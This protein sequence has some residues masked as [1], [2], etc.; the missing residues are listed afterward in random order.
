[1]KKH[2]PNLFT[3]LN[4]SSGLIAI[5][6][7][8]KQDWKT[9]ALFVALGI[10]FDFFD[11][12]AARLLN[13]SSRLG[14]E[15][16]SLADMVT[17]GVA[18]AFT[19]FFLIQKSLGISVLDNFDWDVK[20]LLPFAGFLVAL[21]SA[22]RLAK[23]N[24]DERQTTA[25]IGLPTPANALFIMSLPLI[26]YDKN[27][28]ALS[29]ILLNPYILILIAILSTYILNADI[30]L[31]SLKLKGPLNWKNQKVKI[32]FILFSILLIVLLK[33]LSVPLIILTYIILSIISNKLKK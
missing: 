24:I 21:G 31:F 2:I 26:I 17:S 10:F 27:A 6:F 16:D 25:F 28:T 30:H 1:V 5:L 23:F 29:S 3:L 32:I 14:L 9:A 7:I 33:Y 15:L 19:L 13:V 20:H 8:F 22:Y 11:G 4:L 12:L 18:P